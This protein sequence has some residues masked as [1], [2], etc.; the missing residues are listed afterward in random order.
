LTDLLGKIRRGLRKPPKVILDRVR[1]EFLKQAERL[2]IPARARVSAKQLLAELEAST[3]EELWSRLAQRPR[4]G[5][6]GPAN[7]SDIDTI[8]GESERSALLERADEAL[9]HR[10]NLLGSGVVC[11]GRSIDWHTDFKTG[12]SWPLTF[13]ADIDYSNPDR[14]SD[15]KVPWE[16]S[17]LQWTIPLGQAFLLTR[18]ER[19]AEAARG[20]L[21]QW[22]SGN[23]YGRSVNWS[24][25]MEAAL[26]VFSWSW[27]FYAFNDANSWRDERFR[28]EFLRML[29]LHVEFTD[30]HIERSD[31]N[32][33]HYTA[34]AAALVVG[35]LFFGVG[36]K[37]VQWETEGWRILCHELPLQV[38]SDGVDFEASIPY[39]RLVTE[40]FFW[41]ALCRSVHGL[42]IPKS[43]MDRLVAMGRFSSFYSRG[44]GTVPLI[45]DADDARAIPFGS[46]GIN[47]HRYLHSLIGLFTN[48]L[49]L[50]EYAAP[51]VGEVLWCLGPQAVQRWNESGNQRRDSAAFPEGGFYIM[52]SQDAHIVIDC[53][54]LGLAGRGG[55]GHND[56]LSLEVSL[57]GVNLV[58]DC[59]AY[60]YT[61]SYEE[62]NAFRSTSYHNTP[63]I[64]GEE[65]NRFIRPDYL[66]NLHYDA[67][68]TVRRW[69]VGSRF[70]VFEGQHKGYKRLKD[71][72]IP[73]RTI[74]LDSDTCTVMIHDDFEGAGV[75]DIS[76]PLHLYP[77]IDVLQVS[78]REVRL[79]T[80]KQ[81]FHLLWSQAG[82]YDFQVEPARI[83][84][85]YG[86]AIAS[87]KL[88][89]R[90]RN[91]VPRSLTVFVAAEV[92]SEK[93]QETLRGWII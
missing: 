66:W 11:L 87:K 9:A 77:G 26:R 39:H 64:D 72:V 49:E 28:F 14:P 15:V 57:R 54:P 34:D 40:L 69:M 84:P 41:P 53:G 46:Q 85:S 36:R 45:G 12:I 76:I 19:Y 90:R 91:A 18:D 13:F 73:V 63:Q 25:T 21:E 82:E 43:Y 1:T 81:V 62:R 30:R 52:R 38:F 3:I 20:I 56:C 35:G 67:V 22:I 74:A 61:A 24:C 51:C 60:V 71:A 89:W 48:R 75:H 7:L 86:R 47:D 42:D 44:N 50:T 59:G 93:D 10:V 2:L 80:E 33:N 58:S 79:C 92:L 8:C 16:L 5:W 17:R 31:V 6:F 4:A 29:Y 37:P 27:L 83:S 68:P 78:D 88:V 23:P 70:T 65:I 32:G 55:H